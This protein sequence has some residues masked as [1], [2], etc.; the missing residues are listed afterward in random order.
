MPNVRGMFC[1]V[2]YN[3]VVRDFEYDDSY[4]MLYASDFTEEELKDLVDEKDL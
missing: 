2:S 4:R 1:D 3:F